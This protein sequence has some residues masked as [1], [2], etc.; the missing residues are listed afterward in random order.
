MTIV[1]EYRAGIMQNPRF[2]WVLKLL[3]PV[4]EFR[5]EIM[6]APCIYWA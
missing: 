3:S 5:A 2:Y 4:A 6:R 1:A